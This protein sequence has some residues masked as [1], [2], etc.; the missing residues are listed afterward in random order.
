[1]HRWKVSSQTAIVVLLFLIAAGAA[2]T[3]GV[4]SAPD[5]TARRLDTLERRLALI[6][7][8]VGVQRSSN[9]A[10]TASREQP[11]VL[12]LVVDTLRADHLGLYGYRRRTDP[13]LQ[14]FAQSA[15]VFEDVWA[16]APWTVPSTGSILTGMYPSANG[17]QLKD[18]KP[19]LTAFRKGVTTLAEAF[20]AAGY[21]TVGVVAN[22]WVYARNGHGFARGFDEHIASP[23]DANRLNTVARKHL[24]RERLR[25]VFLYIQYMEPH[26]PYYKF[27]R[28]DPKT[29]GPVPEHY[30]HALTESELAVMPGS[31]RRPGRTHLEEYVDGYDTNI[32]GWDR[33]FGK[34]VSWLRE[35]GQLQKTWIAVVADHGEEFM[36]HGGWDHGTSLFE[37]LLSVPWIL[38]APGGTGL[39]VDRPVS[40]IDVAPTLLAAAGIPVPK[41]MQGVNVLADLPDRPLF[42]ELY[43]PFARKKKRPGPP[44]RYA[45]HRGAHKLIWRGTR[46]NA[47]CVDLGEDPREQDSGAEAPF[48]RALLGDLDRW[49]HGNEKLVEQLGARDG[50][51]AI[52]PSVAE[53]LRALGYNVKTAPK[54][55]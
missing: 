45:V 10:E 26:V 17:L 53:R 34:F 44:H 50:G 22:P 11:D 30:R 1:M 16:T 19:W 8:P 20:H 51:V 27:P 42:A 47:L 37:E 7:N 33:A 54:A 25:P 40:V 36:E 2:Y 15:I 41:T 21:R 5:D 24:E 35:S 14:R 28:I 49:R 43:R 55:P 13:E 52:D 9:K 46:D 23:T 4:R 6:G 32:R 29:L 18:G 31:V 38:R 48:C 39:R 12:L 3:A